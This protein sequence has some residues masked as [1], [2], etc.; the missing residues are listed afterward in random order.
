MPEI[1][2]KPTGFTGPIEIK[3]IPQDAEVS[4]GMEA[5][6]VQAVPSQFATAVQDDSGNQLISSPAISK[7]TLEIPATREQLEL[8]ASQTSD[9]SKKGFAI[10]WIRLIKKALRFGWNTVVKGGN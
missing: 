8:I 1:D 3:E 7:V 4:A 10:F 9:E 6:G 5:G 2:N